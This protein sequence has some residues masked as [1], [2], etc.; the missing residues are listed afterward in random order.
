[1]EPGLGA[2]TSDEIETIHA[3][4]IEPSLIAPSD[5]I[6]I[7]SAPSS[8][9]ER[10]TGQHAAAA[11]QG[12]TGHQPR[13]RTAPLVQ[14][15]GVPRPLDVPKQVV[16]ALEVVEDRRLPKHLEVAN[17]L[18]QHHVAEVVGA[19]Q[20]VVVPLGPERRIGMAGGKIQA[21]AQAA[22]PSDPQ[23]ANRLAFM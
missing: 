15:A 17:A 18:V 23:H 12:T 2:A 19:V 1:M 7:G 10:H 11:G 9:P 22:T 4:E 14:K 13:A 21:C 8:F 16:A 6:R 3:E 5:E 20:I